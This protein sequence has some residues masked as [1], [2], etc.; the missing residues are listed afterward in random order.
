MQAAHK[1]HLVAVLHG[2]STLY[3]VIC[4]AYIAHTEKT[5]MPKKVRAQTRAEN[6]TYFPFDAQA[7]QVASPAAAAHLRECTDDILATWTQT[8]RQTASM[9]Q[10]TAN[11]AFL[12]DSLPLLLK[13]LAD[14][15][16]NPLWRY[17]ATRNNEIA[18]DHGRQRQTARVY[19][20]GEMIDEYAILRHVIC[21]FMP[22]GSPWPAEITGRVHAFIDAAIC[23]AALEFA[24]LDKA[25]ETQSLAQQRDH[26]NDER[27]ASRSDVA[28]LLEERQ[29]RE[30]FVALLSHDLRSPLTS[31]A[32][33][34]QRLERKPGD[35]AF[36]SRIV[37]RVLRAVHRIDHMIQDML[38]ASRLRAG[39]RMP[40]AMAA[41]DLVQ[42][43]IQAQEELAPAHGARIKIQAPEQAWGSWD[44]NAL[45]RVIDNLLGNA[46]KYGDKQA[47]VTVTITQMPQ[48]ARLTVHNHGGALSAQELEILF[49]PYVRAKK[50]EAGKQRGWGLGLT[51]VRGVV[52]AHGGTVGASSGATMGTTFW[53]ELPKAPPVPHSAS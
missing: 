50:A 13:N 12:R 31:I 3:K 1:L 30:R 49:E 40:I 22:P 53:I 28:G 51:L 15:L 33:D 24:V 7:S 45:R 8:V 25:G 10:A 26:A 37:P 5:S 16:E 36:T 32:V 42:V 14:A 4:P 38:D 19:T 43:A 48:S 41:C 23:T 6:D 47:D 44:A 21:G 29:V 18:R 20:I 9:P 2:I 34:A 46:L 39:E 27:D 11:I 17:G 35:A 52:E